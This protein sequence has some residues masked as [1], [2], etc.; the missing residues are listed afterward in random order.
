MTAGVLA[1]Y[2][3]TKLRTINWYRIYPA[4]WVI[5]DASSG[6]TGVASKA[7]REFNRRRQSGALVLR[8]AADPSTWSHYEHF[9]P[10][11]GEIIFENV[12]VTLPPRRLLALGLV[13]AICLFL[14][15]TDLYG[16]RYQIGVF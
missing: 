10:W 7:W 4:G 6:S 12:P 14:Y 3:I 15:H 8:T 2:G 11:Q 1:V 13:L 5:E 9:E 16:G